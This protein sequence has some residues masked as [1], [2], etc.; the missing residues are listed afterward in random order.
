MS[1]KTFF[2]LTL[3]NF[4]ILRRRRIYN[5]YDQKFFFKLLFVS[6][7]VPIVFLSTMFICAQLSIQIKPMLG[8]AMAPT[9]YTLLLLSLSIALPSVLSWLTITLLLRK[10]FNQYELKQTEAQHRVISLVGLFY[11]LKY[12]FLHF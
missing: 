1:W 4:Q 5:D 2:L 8:H 3:R 12:Y 7:S 10:F 6:F 9:H 11:V